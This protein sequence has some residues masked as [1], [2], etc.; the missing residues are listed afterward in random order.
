MYY[1]LMD[2]SRYLFLAYITIFLLIGFFICLDEKRFILINKRYFYFLQ[3]LMIC[4]FHI[5][6]FIILA[7]ND[8]TLSFNFSIIPFFLTSFVFITLGNLICCLIY[9]KS[10]I[11]LWNGIFFLLSIGIVILYRLNVDLAKKQLIWFILG[12]SICLLIPAILSILPRLNLFKYIY[13]FLGLSLLLATLLVGIEEGGAKNWISIK[14]FIFQPAELVKLLF[15]FYLA[16]SF[17]NY[18]VKTKDLI[19]PSIM[20]IVFILCLVFQTDL[21]SALI[22]FMTFLVIVYIATSKFWFI[23]LASFCASIGSIIAYNMFSH[24]KTRVIIW[25]NPF[26][27]ISNKGYQIA[28]SLFAIG[29]YGLMGSGLKNGMPYKIPIVEKDL[30]FSAIC[31]EFGVLF[32]I[33]V[34]LI[35]IMLFY[36]GVR[37]SLDSQNKFLSLLASGMTSLLCFQTF[38]IIGGTIKMIPLTGVTL[39]FIS[40]GGSSIIITF[41]IIG[42]MQWVSIRNIKYNLDETEKIEGKEIKL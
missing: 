25:L 40:Y 37:I 42:I 11:L 35:F 33:C 22:F 24:I 15:I 23:A 4:F 18:N 6:A 21:G 29:T 19:F 38:L 12:F 30:I 7:F 34:I 13:L 2:I 8:D 41:I 3:R 17:S 10:C 26:S 9:K 27:D 16:S 28:Q 31:E 5:T 36:R 14:G 20:S 39:P 1:I 32:A